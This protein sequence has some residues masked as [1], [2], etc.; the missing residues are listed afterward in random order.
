MMSTDF[1][2]SGPVFAA[3]A[4][5]AFFMIPIVMYAIGPL[6]LSIVKVNRAFLYSFIAAVSLLAVY[7]VEN[8]VFQVICAI[9]IGGAAYFLRKN[10]YPVI[11]LLMGFILYPM[12]EYY[13]FT[14]M[15]VSAGNP[16]IFLQ[17]PIS[18]AF[19]LLIPIFFYFLTFRKRKKEA[20]N[21]I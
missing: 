11:A 19:L 6:A 16:I 2:L 7:T 3:L 13:F 18:I 15:Q 9:V 21:D 5:A 10:G 17:R 12:A 8:S 14:A 1:S 4:I 20:R